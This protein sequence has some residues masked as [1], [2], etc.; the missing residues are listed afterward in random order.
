V[1]AAAA[2]L[3]QSAGAEIASLFTRTRLEHGHGALY[4]TSEI[5]AE[6]ARRLI[7]RALPSA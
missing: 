1:L 3:R 4:G 2:A 7:D 5:S 6:E